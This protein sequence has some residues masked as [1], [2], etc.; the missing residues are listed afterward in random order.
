[1]KFLSFIL[2]NGIFI[3][4]SCKDKDR[5]AGKIKSLDS[6]Q[7]EIERKITDFSTLDTAKLNASL[8]EYYSNIKL[9]SDSLK[10]TLSMDY[11]QT[12]NQYK[13]CEA[14]LQFLTENYRS[15]LNESLLSKVQLKKLSTDLKNDAIEDELVFEYYS[16]EKNEA[17]KMSA[18]LSSNF[19]LAKS[20]SDTFVK[21]NKKI[22]QLIHAIETQTP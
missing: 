15:I 22:Q 17:E 12:L 6:L 8:L 18:V 1:M 13:S 11:L 3:L 16:I 20:T 9:L 5:F 14:P 10:D 7:L 2:L 19:K 21:Y 4:Y